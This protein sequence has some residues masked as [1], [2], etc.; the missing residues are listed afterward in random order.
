MRRIKLREY[1]ASRHELSPAELHLLMVHAP[2]LGVSFR[3]VG[4]AQDLYVL[5]TE[6]TVGALEVGCLSVLIEPKIGIPQLLSIAC[7]AMSR[8]KPQPELF[9]YPDR[10]ALPDVL[11]LALSSAA[12]RAFSRGMLH[13]YREEEE[14]LHTVR[15]RIRFEDQIRKRFGVAPPVEVRRDEFTNDIPANRLVKAAATRLLRVRLRSAPASSSL[16]WVVRTLDDVSSVDFPSNDIPVVGFDR[17]NQH[18][19]EVVAL[20]RLVLQHVAYEAGHGEVR[21]CG[22]LMDMSFVFQ[23]FVAQALREALGTADLALRE[24]YIPTLDTKN[25]LRLRPDLTW[26]DASG[27]RFVGDVK[28]KDITGNRAP[29]SDLYQMLAYVTALNLPGGLLIYAKGQED[30]PA[31]QVRHVGKLLR[32]ATIDLT[33]NLDQALQRVNQVATQVKELRDASSGS[34]VHIG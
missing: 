8:F 15:G 24:R 11:A 33:G 25:Q 4:G 10:Y 16:G 21:A 3:P 26:R 9:N 34:A 20:S 22:F 30:G 23:E 29:E 13:G 7:Y 18:Y 28:Y 2:R 1:D 19:R 27:W 31:Y 5:E 32:V 17:L 14:A 12:R 6:S